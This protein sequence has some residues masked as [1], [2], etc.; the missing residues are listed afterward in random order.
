MPGPRVGPRPGLQVDVGT[1]GRPLGRGQH[2]EEA[3]PLERTGAA[4]PQHRH[5]APGRMCALHALHN[6]M[7]NFDVTA[8]ELFTL[9]GQLDAWESALLNGMTDEGW[10]ANAQFDGN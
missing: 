8:R 4:P 10:L 3:P 6:L 7:G 9:A 2:A 1:A 5:Q